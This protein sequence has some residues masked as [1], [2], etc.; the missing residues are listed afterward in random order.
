MCKVSVCR[1]L[2]NKHGAV[3]DVCYRGDGGGDECT[4]G[5]G[6]V[7]LG[8]SAINTEGGATSVRVSVHRALDPRGE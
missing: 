6:Y 4:T 7:A 2:R 1:D 8:G 5:R 3:L